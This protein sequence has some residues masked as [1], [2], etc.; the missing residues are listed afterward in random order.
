MFAGP[1]SRAHG[2]RSSIRLPSCSRASCASRPCLGPSPPV[3]THTSARDSVGPPGR[4]GPS[5]S[6]PL[7]DGGRRHSVDPD[8]THRTRPLCQHT[9]IVCHGCDTCSLA[10]SQVSP[11]SP[12]VPMPAQRLLPPCESPSSTTRRCIPVAGVASRSNTGRYSPLARLVPAV[13][14][15]ATTVLCAT[16]GFTTDCYV[17]TPATKNRMRSLVRDDRSRNSTPTP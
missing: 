16:R 4:V 11:V 8:P 3:G 9:C 12:H 6:N 1:C 15:I 13:R 14:G 2:P 5:G 7:V 10:G 17:R